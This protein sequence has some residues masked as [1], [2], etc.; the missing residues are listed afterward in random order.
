MRG[1]IYW[2]EFPSPKNDQDSRAAYTRLVAVVSS[3]PLN[4]SHRTVIV[5]P[6]TTSP[7]AR[8]SSRKTDVTVEPTRL[9]GLPKTSTLQAHLL[10]TVS[11]NQLDRNPLG[12]IDEGDAFE[13]ECAIRFA[14]DL[15]SDFE[16]F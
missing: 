2:C 6:M 16:D 1:E 4:R 9:N 5:V 13:L 11:K 7:S 14:L 10:T 15:E 12:E 8:E 3:E